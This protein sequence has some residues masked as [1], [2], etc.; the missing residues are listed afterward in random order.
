MAL[1]YSRTV[2]KAISTN[3]QVKCCYELW[4][5]LAKHGVSR[6]KPTRRG[7]GGGQRKRRTYR[8]G[9]FHSERPALALHYNDSSYSCMA[10][11]N[12]VDEDYL[13]NASRGH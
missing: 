3:V 13:H 12:S 2:L 4:L 8:F 7:C 9:V 6:V 11:G 1:V 10:F 5:C